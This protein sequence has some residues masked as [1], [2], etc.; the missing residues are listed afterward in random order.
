MLRRC[1]FCLQG[2]GENSI[3]EAFPGARRMAYD[4]ARGRLWARRGLAWFNFSGV[5][6]TVLDDAV[7]DID[8]AGTAA[9]FLDSFVRREISI[10]RL[11]DEASIAL[12]I[13]V[14][15]A[16]ERQLLTAELDEL[17]ARW[18]EEEEIAAI[19]DRELT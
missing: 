2:F 15:D 7:A 10:R 5:T 1:L 16:H 9:G 3:V 11:T 18:R 8:R 13:A 4:P 17:E 12:E 19:V 14:N 6:D